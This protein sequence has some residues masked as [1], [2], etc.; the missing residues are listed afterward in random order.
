MMKNSPEAVF[1]AWMMLH[2]RSKM[3]TGVSWSSRGQPRMALTHT[4]MNE[5][6]SS[7]VPDVIASSSSSKRS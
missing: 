3:K 4:A 2:S 1:S 7:S 5:A 6:V